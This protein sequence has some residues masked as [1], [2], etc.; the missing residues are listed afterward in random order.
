MRR[1][2]LACALLAAACGGAGPAATTAPTAEAPPSRGAI[3]LTLRLSDGTFLDIG[4]LRGEPILLFVFATFDGVSQAV[5]RPLRA[6]A[7]RHPELRI[8]GIAAQ[9]N[10]RLLIGPY[11]EAL[12]PPFLVA[13]D[14]EDTVVQGTS[15]LGAIDAVPTFIVLDRH[16]RPVARDV[17]FVD[18]AR[19]RELVSAA[20]VR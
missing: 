7:R 12:E 1:S 14:P 6:L 8:V 9:P 18:E 2:T 13:Y 5:L 19:L 17:G 20:G 10:A 16:G 11:E 15:M 4:E 3:E